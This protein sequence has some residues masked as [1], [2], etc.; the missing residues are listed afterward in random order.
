M[1]DDS[2]LEFVVDQLRTLTGVEPRAMFGGQGLYRH[3]TFFGIVH[4]GRLF[5]RTDDGS[6]PEYAARGME[7]FRPNPRQTLTSYYAVPAE[8]LEDDEALTLWPEQA[9]RTRPP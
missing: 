9:L 8:I 2:F 1:A 5:F 6:R 7:P 3:G 4:G